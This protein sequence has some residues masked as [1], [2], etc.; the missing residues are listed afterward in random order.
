MKKII[1]YSLTL[2]SIAVLFTACRKED[3]AQMPGLIRFP[4]PVVA[5][6]AGSDQNISAASPNTFSGKFSVGLYF[7]NDA[8]PKKYDVVAIKNT[9]KTNVK[10]IKADVKSFPTE[11]TLTG[12]QLA[13]LFGGPIVAGDRFDISVDV[14][15]NTGEKFEAFPVTGNPYAAGIAA[16]PAATTFIRYTSQ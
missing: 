12:T 9:D 6:V 10:M 14:Y 13:T 7:P 11:I 15:T 16:Q 4:L 3:N 8:P 2:F 5:K 1:V